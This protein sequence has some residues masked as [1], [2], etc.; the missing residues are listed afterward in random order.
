[1][2]FLVD[3][4][5]PVAL[6]HFIVSRGC[7]CQHVLDVG[8]A[9]ASDRAI[10]RY[11]SDADYVIVTKDEDFFHLAGLAGNKGR[12]LWVRLGNCRTLVLLKEFDRLWPRII[13]L[14]EAGEEVVE[15]R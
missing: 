7:D 5:L 10:W 9:Q 11:A 4:Q 12:L 15:I 2:K 13:S 14:L 8:L 3:N 6:C 1:M